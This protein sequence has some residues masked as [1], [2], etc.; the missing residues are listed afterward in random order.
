MAEPDTVAVDGLLGAAAR[1][2]PR[3]TAI[4][5]FYGDISYA[6]LDR[7]ATMCAAALRGLLGEER[8]V[9][10]V[11]SPVHPDFMVAFYGVIRSGN[12]VAPINPMLPP[13]LLHHL[14]ATSGARLAFV[15][16]EL[17]A[18]LRR[19]RDRLPEL[20]E[21]VLVGPGPRADA[22]DIRTIDDLSAAY[23]VRGNAM[24]APPAPVADDVACI[25]FTSGTTGPPRGVLLSH[26]NL[27]V[28]AAQVAR[29]HRLEPD[30][31][32]LNHLPKFHL[33][34]LNAG[35]Y[36]G[37]TQVACTDSD[38]VAA[39]EAANAS[40]ATHFYTI[41]MKL[42]RLVDDPRLAGLGLTSVRMIASGGS[43]LSARVGRE[44]SAHFGVP[45]FQG[46]GLAETSPLTHSATPD[47]PRPGSVGPT[48]A[49]TECRIVDLESGGVLT[50]GRRGEIQV[51]GPQVMLGYLDP[52]EPTRIDA[53]G[54]LA[55][56]D[57]G[58]LDSE[59]RLFVVDRIK[60]LFKCDNYM[61]SPTEIEELLAAHPLVRESAVVDLPDPVSGAVAAAFVA[62]T[63][64]GPEAGRG[65]LLAGIAEFAGRDV[66]YYQRVR[67]LELVDAV[68]R[69][70]NGKAQRR[71]LRAELVTR[72]ELTVRPT[73]E[74]E[75]DRGFGAPGEGRDLSG[76][77]AAVA[78]FTTKGDPEEFEA[79]FL[80]HVRFMRAQPGFGSQHV[81]TLAA[82]PSVYVNLGW[83][84]NP[85]AFQAIT[86]DPRFQEHQEAMRGLLADA[87]V[88]LHTN[89]FRVDGTPSTG[90]AGRSVPPVVMLSRYRLTGSAEEF[91]GAFFRYAKHLRTLP[92]F[93]WADLG[94]S[95]A[96][97]GLY[98]GVSY[99][100][101]AQEQWRAESCAAHRGLAEFAEVRQERLEHLAW[102]G[103]SD[104]AGA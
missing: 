58:Y 49:D 91:E 70:P 19:V 43:A 78:R 99:W 3:K 35:V 66:P 53:D 37:A 52:D 11:A 36:A 82:D 64:P 89:L 100:W 1:E 62:L 60:D 21:A 51:R 32:L 96:S 13:H 84:L 7:A 34:H 79:F 83:W 41:P 72:R 98:T 102:N 59:D 61:V 57:I 4:R 44:L 68:P 17:F 101:D 56:G 14:L 73:G 27:T 85:A 75:R 33:M 92:G 10:A 38:N 48:V 8:C 2:Y 81:L 12:I 42:N 23:E 103:P 86:Q 104:G 25:Q 77:V 55:T 40:G 16:A 39:V 28:N 69:S 9:V 97:P 26:R 29:A 54:W 5:A 76:L 71:E 93:G 6:E 22:N 94:R 50:A 31:V 87:E 74:P 46:Y 95:T 45:V 67:H 30:S 24:S 90:E 65:Q 80:E 47:D 18:S 20:R 63:E 88:D 15:T